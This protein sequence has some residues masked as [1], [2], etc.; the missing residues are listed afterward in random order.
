MEKPEEATHIFPS[1]THFYNFG[2][3]R[4]I[5]IFIPF[6]VVFKLLVFTS[7]PTFN[8]IPIFG[9]L[10][11]RSFSDVNSNKNRQSAI[12]KRA[13]NDNEIS[14]RLIDTIKFFPDRYEK[15]HQKGFFF[16]KKKFPLTMAIYK[17][18]LKWNI[19]PAKN[20]DESFI[21]S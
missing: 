15:R 5:L 17:K 8:W 2:K 7:Q 19:S 20:R 21:K 13:L 4:H 10:F 1:Q 14:R 11:S 12:V 18:K 3:V 16:K 9:V 6:F